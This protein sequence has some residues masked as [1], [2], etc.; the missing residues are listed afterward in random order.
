MEEVI[1]TRESGCGEI[2]FHCILQS[3]YQKNSNKRFR[4]LNGKVEAELCHEGR[5]GKR[6][7]SV[8]VESGNVLVCHV[9]IE[10]KRS[11]HVILRQSLTS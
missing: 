7:S 9:L 10:G 5:V 8:A 6:S 2:D 3:T 4:K 11:P 1:R